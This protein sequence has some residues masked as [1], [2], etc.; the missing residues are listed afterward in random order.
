MC[1]EVTITSSND[2]IGRSCTL[3]PL[4]I[5]SK[6]PFLCYREILQSD[7]ICEGSQELSSRDELP[8]SA[9]EDDTESN[10]LLFFLTSLKEQKEKHA[11]KL[12]QDIA[13]LEAD[14]NEVET[15]NLLKMTSTVSC[16]RTDFAHGRG[17][18]C[19][20]PE[21]PMNPSV[22]YKSIAGSN[23]NE[24]ILTKNIRQLEN[25]YFSLR[26]KIELSETNMESRPDKDLLKN[27]NKL[28]QMQ[29][30][31]GELSM[32]QKP[33]G[34]LGTF[35]EGLCKF[36]RYS[37]F[38]VRG[39]LRNGDLLNSTNVTC[40]LS[41]DRDQDYMAAAG[42]S[43]KIKIFE[44]DSLLNDSV[45]IHYPVVEMSNK[46][47]L[48]C[49]CWNSYIKNYLASTDYDGVVQVCILFVGATWMI[50]KLRKQR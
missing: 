27:R 48:S 45:D 44:F 20:C 12:V 38:E 37:K 23:V 11:A 2:L 4:S 7:L 42:V 49:V 50:T 9:D 6:T 28:T 32:N 22:H 13:C 17:K 1:N 25:A 24:K 21:G 14:L 47:K 3:W 8:S 29:N 40:S 33:K 31:D 18:Q 34:Q 26:S 16:I 41:F 46:S 19:L 30:D 35:F 43:K 39:T 5:L 10:L 15:K 36:A